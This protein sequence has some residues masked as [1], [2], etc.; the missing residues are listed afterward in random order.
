MQFEFRSK[1][2]TR[3]C[4]L[5]F[6]ELEKYLKENEH[7]K[8]ME[9]L[10]EKE[11]NAR[12]IGSNKSTLLHKAVHYKRAWCVKT[13][14]DNGCSLELE[15]SEGSTCFELAI[16]KGSVDVMKQLLGYGVIES[17]KLSTL[18]DLAQRLNRAEVLKILRYKEEEKDAKNINKNMQS[19]NIFFKVK[20]A[21]EILKSKEVEKDMKKISDN[22][23]QSDN[24]FVRVKEED[25][26]EGLENLNS[27]EGEKDMKKITDNGVQSDNGFVRIK[28]EDDETVLCWDIPDIRSVNF[29]N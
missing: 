26:T 4:I 11:E 9:L 12:I 24:V 23:V 1:I 21:L 20:E 27:K 29:D 5:L 28:E 13:L 3:L 22:G 6:L 14:L 10:N 2:F 25:Q 19:D 8:F 17:A 7:D 15:D 18:K 16:F